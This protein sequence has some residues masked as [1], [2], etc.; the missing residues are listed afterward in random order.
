MV[1]T[2]LQSFTQVDGWLKASAPV[3]RL[4]GD[5]DVAPILAETGIGAP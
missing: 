4:A 5:G 1:A 2:A 3:C